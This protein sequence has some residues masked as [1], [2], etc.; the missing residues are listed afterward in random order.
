MVSA[1]PAIRT[2]VLVERQ[3]PW[4]VVDLGTPNQAS[5]REIGRDIDVLSQQPLN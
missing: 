3:N 5:I 4:F 2:E 1:A